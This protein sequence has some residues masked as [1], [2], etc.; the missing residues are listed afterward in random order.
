MTRSVKKLMKK[1]K[2]KIDFTILAFLK[3]AK[4]FIY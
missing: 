1:K 2:A 4:Y 3:E